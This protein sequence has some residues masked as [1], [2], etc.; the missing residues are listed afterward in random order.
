MTKRS[1]LERSPCNSSLGSVVSCSIEL[2]V[3]DGARLAKRGS[4][5]RLNA[6]VAV[7]E[8]VATTGDE[9]ASSFAA[10]RRGTKGT[11]LMSRLR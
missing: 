4:A 9:Y 2:Y 10:T 1:I 3:A 6:V 11:I 7:R 8:R 5:G